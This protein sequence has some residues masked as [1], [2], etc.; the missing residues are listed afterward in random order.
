MYQKYLKYPSLPDDFGTPPSNNFAN[1]L[2]P[3]T[4]NS[5]TTTTKM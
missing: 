4:V 5:T 1:N 3:E 2:Y